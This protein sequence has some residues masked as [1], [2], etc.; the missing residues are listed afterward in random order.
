M[1]HG[2]FPIRLSTT[3]NIFGYHAAILLTLKL[4]SRNLLRFYQCTCRKFYSSLSC[5]WLVPQ[6]KPPIS[7]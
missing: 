4:T 5:G 6:S 1:M 7:P 3:A 2:L